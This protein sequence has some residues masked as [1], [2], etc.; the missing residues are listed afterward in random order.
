MVSFTDFIRTLERLG[1]SDV[2]LPFILIFTIVFAVMQKAQILGENRKF[3]A[4]IALVLALSVIIPH[5]TNSYPDSRYDVVEIINT[6]LPNVS[7]IAVAVVAVM[8]LLG[9]LGVDYFKDIKQASMFAFSLWAFALVVVLYIF[10]S[11][12]G[13]GW[14]IPNWL[15]FLKDPDTQALLIIILVFGALIAYI[16]RPAKDESKKKSFFENWSNAMAGFM[17]ETPGER[18][19]GGQGQ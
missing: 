17:G 10:G 7:I 2:I 16:T 8:I 4:A 15:G 1:L 5:V 19:G 3:H 9:L 6:S 13:W 14:T 11:A 12:A 18:S